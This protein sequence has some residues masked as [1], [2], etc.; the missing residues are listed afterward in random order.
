MWTVILTGNN[1]FVSLCI[2]IYT[3]T[4]TYS[5]LTLLSRIA[6]IVLNSNSNEKRSCLIPN[7]FNS[8]LLDT[9]ASVAL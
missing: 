6:S 1:N 2:Y 3:H 4:D 7:A 8:S 9:F 5:S